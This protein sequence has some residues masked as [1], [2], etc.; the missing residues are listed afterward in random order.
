MQE[1]L[2]CRASTQYRSVFSVVGVIGED[3]FAE[4]PD[5]HVLNIHG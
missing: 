2:S 5:E 1:S 3:A 4:M